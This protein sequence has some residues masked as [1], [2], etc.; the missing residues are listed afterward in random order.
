[1]TPLGVFEMYHLYS[2]YIRLSS[3]RF[4]DMGNAVDTLF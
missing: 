1:M 4:S 2:C 3:L